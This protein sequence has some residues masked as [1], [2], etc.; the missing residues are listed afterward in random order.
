V[1]QSKLTTAKEKRAYIEYQ[2]QLEQTRRAIAIEQQHQAIQRQESERSRLLTEREFS[3]AQIEAKIQDIDYQIIQLSSVLAPYDGT[4]KKV[5]WTGQSD[6]NLTAVV[7]LAINDSRPTIANSTGK[8][9]PN[10]EVKQT[11]QAQP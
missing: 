2:R 4:I 3:Q 7:T 1:A 10:T 8:P 6:H 5:K 9:T 11:T